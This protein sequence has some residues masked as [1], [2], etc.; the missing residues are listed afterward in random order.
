MA[1][2]LIDKST[3]IKTSDK[4]LNDL[5]ECIPRIENETLSLAN[6]LD[7]RILR[8]ID[9]KTLLENVAES[10]A[11]NYQL[12]KTASELIK[13]IIEPYIRKE[14]KLKELWD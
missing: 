1:K 11:Q 3:K 14:V 4:K 7:G 9:S 12:N 13:A 5:K 10:V 6:L 2:E 8:G